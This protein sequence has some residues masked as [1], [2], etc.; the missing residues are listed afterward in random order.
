MRRTFYVHFRDVERT[1]P[2][3]KEM[4]VDE[5]N[6]DVYEIVRLLNEVGFSGMMI[7]DHTPHL[8]G[9][10]DWEHRGRSYTVGFIRGIIRSL[11]EV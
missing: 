5:G 11:R 2:R 1:V 4:F 3:F 9:D 8:E 10:T 7:P 6:Y